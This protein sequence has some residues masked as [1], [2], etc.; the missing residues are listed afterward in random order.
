M[1]LAK[2]NSIKATNL[3]ALVSGIREAMPE[4]NMTITLQGR[5]GSTVY[6][7]APLGC[8]VEPVFVV[9]DTDEALVA[10]LKIGMC[11]MLAQAE[12]NAQALPEYVERVRPRQVGPRK[13]SAVG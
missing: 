13:L 6:V 7:G 9:A 8:L 12:G 5:N 1:S 4:L 11:R 3:F 10:K 2:F